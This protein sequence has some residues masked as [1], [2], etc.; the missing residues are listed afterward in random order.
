MVR[1]SRVLQHME[2]QKIIFL[3]ADLSVSAVMF[4][5]QCLAYTVLID[6]CYHAIHKHSYRFQHISMLTTCT[7]I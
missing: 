6:W 4:C 2:T 1:S 5:K 3:N 7:Y